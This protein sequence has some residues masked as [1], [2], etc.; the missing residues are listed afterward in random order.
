MPASLTLAMVDSLSSYERVV[1]TLVEGQKRFCLRKLIHLRVVLSRGIEVVVVRSQAGVFKG[2]SLLGGEHSEGGTY[3]HAH[4][5]DFLHHGE[6]PVE[7]TL[8]STDVSPCSAHTEAGGASVFSA[9]CF[10]YYGIEGEEF[11]SFCA[12]AVSGGLGAVAAVFG[13]A[14]CFDIHER[15]ELY[16][17]RLV[18]DAV[19][20][21]L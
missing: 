4:A 6:D 3:F 14:A 17:A 8:A 5:L 13:T 21:G 10:L 12:S 15:A 2:Y 11:T 1:M 18:M 19:Y 7:T 20:A 9:L 16:L